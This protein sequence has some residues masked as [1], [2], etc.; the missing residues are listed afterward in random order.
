MSAQLILY[1]QSYN[2]TYTYTSA[3][4]LNQYVAAGNFITGINSNTATS[5]SQPSNNAVT[6]STPISAWK[7]FNSTGGTFASCTAPSV[8]GQGLTL[9][10]SGSGTSSTGVYQ[11]IP[12][13]IVGQC[14][15]LKI[16]ISSGSATGTLYLG[17]TFNVTWV[18]GATNYTNLGGVGA[19]GTFWNTATGVV[20]ANFLFAGNTSEVLLL[21]YRN[22]DGSSIIISDISLTEC[23][24]TVTETYDDLTDG[25]VI[26]DLY[27]DESIPLSLSIDDFKNVAEKTQSYS[28]DFHLPNT[29]RNKKIFGHIFEVTRSTD[30][31]SFN[32][33]IKTRAILKEDSY[34]LF[35]GFLQLINI[36]DK[37]GE[38]SYNVNLYSEVVTLAE[39]L[40]ESKFYDLDFTE[41]EHDYTSTQV[42]NSW[43]DSSTG[44][45]YTNAGTSGFRDANDTVKYPFIDWTHTFNLAS[46]NFPELNSLEEAFRPCIQV[47]YLIDRIF[48]STPFTYESTLFDSTDFKKLYMDFNWGADN[49]PIDINATK[50]G[51]FDTGT[52]YATLSW[53]S[54]ELTTNNFTTAMGYGS[55]KFEAQVDNVTFHI[56]YSFGFEGFDV[57]SPVLGSAFSFRWKMT[58]GG[59]VSY[60]DVS[61]WTGM[62]LASSA[63]YSNLF[64]SGSLTEPLND[65]DTLEPQFIAFNA[66]NIVQT[67]ANATTVTV[68]ITTPIITTSIILQT[69]RGDL[70]QWEFLK[71]IMTMFNLISIS[72]RDNPSNIIIE[73]YTDIF[74]TNS[75]STQRNWTDKVDIS[76]INLK[77]LELVK[78]TIFKF[79][80]DDDDYAFKLYKYAVNGHLYGSQLYDGS[81]AIGNQISSLMGEEE[82]IAEPY[83]ATVVKPL[84]AQ[85]SDFITPSIYSYNSDDGTSEGFE[86]SPRILYNNGKKTLTS[87]TYKIPAQNGVSV[88]NAEDEFL[89]F[90]HLSDIP[91][92]AGTTTDF[93]FGECQ[94]I[95]PLIPVTDNLYNT[96]WSQYYDELYHP[97]T[98]V[99]TMKVNLTPA[100]IQNFKFYDTVVIKNREYRV[101]KIEYK[102]STLA[103][104]EF[105]LI[106]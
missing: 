46:N 68:T 49:A 91:T 3:P 80:E 106:P 99:M 66:A 20:G 22:D 16:T 83:G 48:Q 51:S 96:Y 1:P 14:Y 71:G 95:L 79:V 27:E 57:T 105:I 54:L 13:L 30:A 76:E 74:L 93:H 40:K 89:Q 67:S 5:N 38:I 63:P 39:V 17:N 92:I 101:N 59:V 37:E 56:A 88:I 2:G 102:P 86:N 24:A 7:S 9:R 55:D 69:L 19:A 25:Q 82:I 8:S 6:T 21:D 45:T 47:K 94:L 90:S 100:D 33:Y 4:V 15:E 31:F 81:T 10:S 23:P 44:I 73:P 41:L 34:T 104:V 60:I 97:D 29:K 70:A 35:E 18:S 103:K 98:R 61:N 11:L 32:P 65:G 75:N 42:K 77:P 72:D 84:M 64:W 87:C 58:K 50:S 43:N 28:K 12:N 62:S 36:N 85:F 26:C 78:K 52:N 53:S